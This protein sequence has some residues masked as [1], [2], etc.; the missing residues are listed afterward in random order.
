MLGSLK[1]SWKCDCESNVAIKKYVISWLLCALLKIDL[2]LKVSLYIAQ[3]HIFWLR[4]HHIWSPIWE[5]SYEFL[6][7]PKYI[8]TTGRPRLTWLLWQEKNHLSQNH[9]MGI[10]K[11]NIVCLKKTSITWF[12]YVLKS[13]YRNFFE[14]N[15]NIMLWEIM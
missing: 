9:V 12:Y 3:C 6:K 11:W 15:W 8:S 2:I 5:K 7:N 14:P 13:C 4:H 1:L 10:S